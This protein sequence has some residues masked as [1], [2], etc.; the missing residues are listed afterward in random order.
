MIPN[1]W[2]KGSFL[3]KVSINDK[4]NLYNE[5]IIQYIKYKLKSSEFINNTYIIH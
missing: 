5:P 4:F 3:K 2:L 1:F